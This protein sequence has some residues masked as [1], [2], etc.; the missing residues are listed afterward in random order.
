M[1]AIVPSE[2]GTGPTSSDWSE[3]CPAGRLSGGAVFD[4]AWIS[5]QPLGLRPVVP[6]S[7]IVVGQSPEEAP[8][9]LTHWGA[10]STR[11]WAW[12]P[13]TIC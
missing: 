6:Y 13:S 11:T 3:P 5:C 8:R 12:G 7:P 1:Q 2:A 4:I 10:Q 9:G